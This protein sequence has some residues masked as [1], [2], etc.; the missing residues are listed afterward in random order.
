MNAD[1]PRIPQ[2]S[3]WGE[4]LRKVSSFL[5]EHG[6]VVI[7]EIVVNFVAPFIAYTLAKPSLGEVSALMI[8]SAPPIAWSLFEFAR[9]RR[10]DALSLLVLAG[11]A[12][13]LLAFVGGGGVRFLQLRERLVTGA[14]GLIFLGS[15]AIGRPLMYELA[16]A[17]LKRS[18][19]AEAESLDTLKQNAEFRR[20]MMV[21]TVVWGIGLIV[22]CAVACTLVFMLTVPQYLVVNPILGYAA[23]GA[24]TAWT[25]WYA[26]RGIEDET[27]IEQNGERTRPAQENAESSRTRD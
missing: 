5:R 22:E 4:R 10:V 1:I 20:A 18:S 27:G 15:A 19:P 2:T 11:I 23:A 14:L 21:M 13:S 25:F 7:I 16:R 8:S 6:R 3:S 26:R 24:L 12:L 17:R 9:R